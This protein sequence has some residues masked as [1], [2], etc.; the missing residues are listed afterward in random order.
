ML[1]ILI[2]V[3]Q[4][5]L[6]GLLA[7]GL[8]YASPRIGLAP[9]LFLLAA[10]IG[11]LNIIELNALVIVLPRNVVMRPGGHIF[12]PIS[13][14]IILLLYIVQGTRTAQVAVVGI[15]G[16]NL[17]VFVTLVFLSLYVNFSGADTEISGLFTD[18]TAFNQQFIR[19]MLASLVAY[20]ADMLIL[21]IVFQG[22]TNHLKWIPSVLVAGIALVI[23]LWVDSIVFNIGAFVGTPNFDLSIP[24]DILIKTS[25]GV[26]LMPMIG[27]Y[28]TR[29]APTLEM[30]A[31]IEKRPTLGILFRS[32][33][34]DSRIETLE[35]E[36]RIGRTVY[37]Q[38]TQH[39]EEIFW[40]IDV[41]EQRFIYV[42]PAYERI[43]KYSIEA[44]YQDANNLLEIIHP[45]DRKY[46][47]DD[48]LGFLTQELN[49]EFR[50]VRPNKIERH[51]RARYFPI[52]DETGKIF[53]Y[54][55]IAEDITE[56]KKLTEQDFELV[57]ARERMQILHDFIRDASHD[58]KT[59]ISA[60]ILKIGLLDRL[61]DE[62]RRKEIRSELRGRALYLSDFITDL[63]TLSRIEADTNIEMKSII[64]NDIV[65]GAIQDTHLLAEEKQLD[66]TSDLT[67]DQTNFMGNADQIHRVVSN[68]IS[69]AIRYTTD[70]SIQIT[71]RIENAQLVFCVTDTGI[72]IA[73][74]S[75]D[76]VF[77]RFFRTT[78]AIDTQEGTG[79]GLAISKAIVDKHHGQLIVDSVEGEGSIFT[80]ILPTTQPTP[81]VQAQDMN[82][83]T[84][85]IRS[86]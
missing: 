14:L 6:F 74:D 10:C 13:L 20:M 39:I 23:A 62:D 54:A 19:G 15:M 21:I 32:N 35:S 86:I 77:D 12:I 5:I 48:V 26:I 44:L 18:E 73:E 68:L 49:V 40:L 82:R 85:E 42:S 61:E 57:L 55:G 51:L 9:L 60:M 69:N 63:F 31:G 80:L 38:L 22:V 72:G 24:S 79:L 46:A 1:S 50:I 34:G 53:R 65:Q 30:F 52:K 36:L 59:P 83:R 11:L 8:H 2:F 84:Q 25:A 81:K 64:L 27:V 37:N 71:T 7:I 17:F 41:E 29:I 47:N 16:V 45:D 70:G 76:R 58:L 56:R 4:L 75:I 43:T 3:V 66:F 33:L 28:I 67:Q 78:S